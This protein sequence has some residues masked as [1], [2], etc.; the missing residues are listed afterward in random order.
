MHFNMANLMILG[1]LLAALVLLFRSAERIPAAIAV[2]AAGLQALIAFRLVTFHGPPYLGLVLA[3]SLAVAG[4]WAWSSAGSKPA[5]S[6][7][8]VVALIG[9]IQ[10]LIALKLL[11]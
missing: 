7:A 2:V 9:L 6:A 4:L 1:A 3:A 8:T 10:L 5:V 11:A